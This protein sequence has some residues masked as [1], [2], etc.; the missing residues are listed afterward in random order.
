VPAAGQ[1][2]LLLDGGGGGGGGVLP[3]KA[4]VFVVDDG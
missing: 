1:L 3:Q 2:L 4:F